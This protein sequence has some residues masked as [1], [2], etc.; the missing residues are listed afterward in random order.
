MHTVGHQEHSLGFGSL[1]GGIEAV[2]RF[3]SRPGPTADP[4]LGPRGQ[5]LRDH[6]AALQLDEAQ[7]LW[8][9]TERPAFRALNLG[10]GLAGGFGAREV[11]ISALA[12]ERGPAFATSTAVPAPV[13][14]EVARPAPRFHRPAPPVLA[15]T[16][17]GRTRSAVE[18]DEADGVLRCRTSDQVSKGL[19][20]VLGADELLTTIG[21]GAVPDEVLLLAREAL[22]EDPHLA[23]WRARRTADKGVD[24]SAV[25]RRMASE[26]A[27]SFAYYAGHEELIKPLAG[28]QPV[29]PVVRQQVVEGLSR[30]SLS[31]AVWTH[32]E[33]VTMWGQPWRPQHCD[34]QVE[35]DLGGID[36]WELVGDDLD[37]TDAVTTPEVVVLQGRSPLVPGS[38]GTVVAAIDRWLKDERAR[39]LDGHGLADAATEQALAALRD[40]LAGLDLLTVTF[41]GIR[42]QLL[43]YAYAQGLLR[44]DDHVT[45][46]GARQAVVSALPRLVAA[47]RLRLT[48]ARLVDSWGRTLALPVDRLVV[49]ERTADGEPGVLRLRPRLQAPAR[50]YLRLV[51]PVPTADT[52]ATARVD[53]ADAAAQVNPVAGFLLP[54]HIDESLEVFATDGTPL[55]SLLHDAFSDA[56]TWEGAPGRTD[57]GRDAGPTEDADLAHRRVGWMA[58][59][60]VAADAADRDGRPQRRETE[61]SLSALLRAIDTTLWTVDPFGTTGREHIAGL[62]GRPIA[63]VTARLTLEVHAGDATAPTRA[64][65]FDELASVV[66]PVRLGD[67]ARAD[68]GL[69]G[70][71]VDDDFG[72]FHVVD[73]SV[74]IEARES[75]R[76]RGPLAAPG[77]NGY[78]VHDQLTIRP[79]QVVKLTLLMHPGGRAHA[80]C[81]VLP[82]QHVALSREWVQP[83]LAVLSPSIR[84]GP[85]LVDPDK[86]R[87]P[88]VAAFPVAQLFTRRD[89]PTSWKDDPILAATQDAL[90]PDGAAT[91]QEG[92]IRV[93][94]ARPPGTKE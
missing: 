11:S 13:A 84:V 58:A 78:V 64:A 21:S 29:T 44:H 63:V 24:A 8:S 54:D 61:S 76:N 49:P 43:G 23:S 39:D 48:S 50:L 88:K 51:D 37:P 3:V 9:A 56:V 27:V 46:D 30:L 87:F 77:T 42:E 74:L 65:A 66:V 94:P 73:P 28:G 47:G 72:H 60:V 93:G 90:L 69:L 22:A 26:A 52:A 25:G 6:R 40:H 32:P 16:G 15:I 86:V 70:Y 80:V 59:G 92:W 10:A 34:W 67:L 55:G 79:G 83:G 53:M 19:A 7:V 5:A 12:I 38:A 18:R 41:D 17:G 71:F 57:V 85:L 89:S 91:I 1:P 31:D 62:V 68:D 45:A 14:R 75:G 36:G 35:L 81:G 2:D 4:A 82:R 20:G 33:G